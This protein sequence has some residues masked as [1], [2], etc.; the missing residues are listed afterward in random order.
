MEESRPLER[1]KKGLVGFGASLGEGFGYAKAAVV[2]FTK[3]LTAKSEED[4]TAADLQTAK[5]QVAAADHAEDIK[6]KA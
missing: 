6:R 3:K 1:M 2:G 5:M 4:A